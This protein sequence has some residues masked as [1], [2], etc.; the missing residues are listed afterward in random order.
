MCKAVGFHSELHGSF[1][2]YG[3][4]FG[5]GVLF[6]INLWEIEYGRFFRRFSIYSV[7][8][9]CGIVAY[10][11]LIK[12]F[13]R[14]RDYMRQFYVY[15]FKS[16]TEYNKKSA[17]SY[18]NERRRLESWLG[19]FM[20]FRQTADGKNVFLSVDTR[21]IPSNPLYNAFKAKSF[22]AGDVTF[23]F[24]I[25]DLL[26]D[27]VA[28]TAQEIADFFSDKYLCHFETDWQPDLSTIRKKLKE[29]V[30]LGLLKAEKQG[31]EMYFSRTK[32]MIDLSR[33]ENALTFFSEADPLGVIGSTMLDKLDRTPDHYQFKHHHMLHAL[34]SEIVLALLYAIGEK[35]RVRLHNASQHR[36]KKDDKEIIHIV[37]PM[38]IYVSSQDGRQFLL[39]YH[40]QFRRIMFFRLDYVRKVETIEEEKHFEKYAE[41]CEKFQKHLWGASSGSGFN[42]DHLEL[43]LHFEDD[44]QYIPHRLEREKRNGHVEILDEHTCRF[45]IDVYD[46]A[47]LIPWLRTENFQYAR[48]GAA[49]S[50]GLYAGYSELRALR[51]NCGVSARL[52]PRAAE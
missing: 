42:L 15:G 25:L 16:R 38:K 35:R 30:S 20:R 50:C 21:S 11:E 10:S 49:V 47:E 46:A 32:D 24:C 36:K 17:R 45:T 40:Y 41:S 34:D 51:R 9:G 5:E 28:Y 27:D 31:R 8:R 13:D 4:A 52:F 26:C 22:T 33:W 14:I 12:S 29:Y 1:F 39:C 2:G 3:G 44:E 7:Q 6:V 18:D 37:L 23:R 48:R 43:M 19:D